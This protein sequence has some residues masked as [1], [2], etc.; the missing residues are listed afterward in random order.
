MSA[1]LGTT[2][3]RRLRPQAVATLVAGGG[4]AAW[5]VSAARMRGMDMGPGTDLGGLGWFL[6]I[7]VTMTAAMMLPSAVPAAGQ[8]ARLPRRSPT[9]LFVAGYLAVWTVYG[10]AAYGLDRFLGSLD[11]G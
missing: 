6:G 10:L 5:I 2:A 1:I 8:V 7:W 4:L 11:T 3:A 9:V